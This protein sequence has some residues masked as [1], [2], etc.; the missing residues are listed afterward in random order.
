MSAELETYLVRLGWSQAHFAR[1][2]G[3][4]Q[5]TVNQWKKTGLPELPKR[6]LEQCARLLG[7]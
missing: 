4:S 3:V 5:R 6:Y 1:L 7:V 2:C